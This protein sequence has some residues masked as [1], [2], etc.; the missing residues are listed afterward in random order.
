M[1]DYRLVE[2]LQS[3]KAAAWAFMVFLV[4]VP[5]PLPLKAMCSIAR[6]L[7]MA[8]AQAVRRI[9]ELTVFVPILSYGERIHSILRS[10]EIGPV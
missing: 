2:C 9:L 6:Y 10:F 5:R 4:A 7:A 3:I 8:S 1:S